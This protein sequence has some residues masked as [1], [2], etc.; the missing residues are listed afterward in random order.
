MPGAEKRSGR[1]LPVGSSLILDIRSYYMA[2]KGLM[3][4]SRRR[5]RS[6]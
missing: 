4:C 5:S 6:A 2:F 3:Y 1:S